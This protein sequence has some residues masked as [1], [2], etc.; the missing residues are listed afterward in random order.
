MRRR[1]GRPAALLAALAILCIQL[2]SAAPPASAAGVPISG[3]GSSF[4]ALELDQWRADT[5]RVP[6][7]LGV[8]YVSQ[9][10][11]FG[12]QQFSDGNLDFGASDITFLQSEI[13]ELRS[14]RCAG[15]DP[16]TCFVYVPVSAGGVSFMYN[17]QDA[18]GRR[19]SN[20][21]LTRDQA[22]KIFTG[23]ITTWGQLAGDNPSLSGDGNQIIPIIRADGAGESYVFSQFCI[24]V[25]QPVWAAFIADRKAHDPQNVAP[26]FGQGQPVSNWPQNWGR[27]N[28][29]PFGDGVANAVADPTAGQNAI[30]YTAA[31]YAKVRSFPVASVQNAAGVFTQPT[32]DNVTV[33]LGYAS[34]QADPNGVPGTFALNFSGPDP[35][36]Y[37]PSTYSYV[38]AQANGF[39]PA[40]GA[41]LGEFLCYAISKGQEIAPLLAYARLSAPLVQISIN[42]ISHIPGA[43]PPSSCFLAGSA[44]P[45]G[46][47]SVLG[48]AGGTTAN[49]TPANAN[50]NANANNAAAAK[51]SLA[52]KLAQATAGAGGSGTKGWA[53]ESAILTLL[54]GSIAAALVVAGR[55]R[56]G[57]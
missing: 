27:A 30:T 32:E 38:I 44:Q 6:F 13:P 23:Q 25:D 34:P 42:A 39:S 11:S 31:G 12:R 40:K 18:S 56:A 52:D 57:L 53:T 15:Q 16:S 21:Q 43:P 51:Q 14:H 49:T 35:R 24:S 45:P 33:A 29:V 54:V 55:R 36:A 10:S 20:L 37:F 5:A 3:G 48:G 9:G 17:K 22:C 46:A 4:A 47:P 19:M 28:P 2:V 1:Y 8:N 41:T 50:A 7:S 26:D